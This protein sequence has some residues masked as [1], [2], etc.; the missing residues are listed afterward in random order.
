[1]SFGYG[2]GL[3]QSYQLFAFEQ[4][5]NLC[6]CSNLNFAYPKSGIRLLMLDSF[7]IPLSPFHLE[8]VLHLSL[9]MLY[10]CCLYLDCIRWNSWVSTNGVVSRTKF[11]YLV[12]DKNIAYFDI[13]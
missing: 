3:S 4:N 10:H 6:S 13:P 7:P 1:M 5:I 11:V 8:N 2:C 9:R 12:K